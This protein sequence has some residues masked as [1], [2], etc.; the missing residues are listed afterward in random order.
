MSRLQMM[1]FATMRAGKG[2]G[3]KWFLRL[4]F[5]FCFSTAAVAAE[6]RFYLGTY[7]DNPLSQGI[8]SGMLDTRT[9]RISPLE[10]AAK[11]TSP[12]YLALS[13]DG[14]FL[15][16]STLAG[17]GSV[18][19]F[20][21][22]GGGRLAKLNE[23]SS[24]GGARHRSVAAPGR[25]LLVANYTGGSAACFRIQPD[26]SVGDRTAFVPLTG[27]GPNPQ[28]QT[29]PHIHSIYVDAAN[30]FVYACDLGTD[31]V[32]LF[33]FEA[34]TGKLT[35]VNEGSGK[36]PPGSGT[37]HFA[38][39]PD[40]RFAY[41][42]GEMG[43]NVTVFARDPDNGALTAL[44][45]VSNLPAGV[46]TNDVTTAEIFCHPSGKWLYVSNR[47]LS[48]RGRDSIAVFGIAA[49]GRLKWIQD[50]PAQVKVPRGFGIDPSGQWLI[51][52][53]QQDNRIAVFK[54]DAATGW[55]TPTGQSATIGAPI[56]VIFA[57]T[58]KR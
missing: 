25:D 49:A 22:E 7:T 34:Q 4:A 31:H 36:M 46:A 44:Q 27:S 23:I 39:S 11:T 38:I 17:D 32:W 33:D 29:H 8:Y 1:T 53:G 48:N 54:I 12:N 5:V 37:R 24:G 9:G 19:A 41:A 2:N 21:V 26:G 3:L 43:L 56:C 58:E 55:L 20:R 42:N 14:K 18:A 40:G 52:A 51:A 57:A 10:L 50:A 35:L 6:I 15:Y 28:R 47:D 13:P 16:A 30:R 45:T